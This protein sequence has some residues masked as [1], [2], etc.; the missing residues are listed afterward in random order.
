MSFDPYPYGFLPDP[1]WLCL[2]VSVVGLILAVWTFIQLHRSPESGPLAVRAD[3]ADNLVVSTQR[4][5]QWE[6]RA[7]AKEKDRIE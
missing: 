2:T 3:A 5:M 6:T 1:G 7:Q 4:G